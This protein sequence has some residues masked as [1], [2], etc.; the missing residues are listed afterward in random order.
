MQM[1]AFIYIN[2]NILLTYLACKSILPGCG[3]C[4]QTQPNTCLACSNTSYYLSNGN[5]LSCSTKDHCEEC[6]PNSDKC[7]KCKD[8]YYP[9]GNGICVSCENKGCSVCDG[10][11]G[12][13]NECSTGYYPTDEGCKLCS[14][15]NK[16]HCKTCST[17]ENQCEECDDGY[18]PNGDGCHVQTNTV[19]NA[20]QKQEFVLHVVVQIM[21]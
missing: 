1:F 21:Y 3:T 10:I 18:Y 17:K 7:Y 16:P 19:L 8:G 2:D 14:S 9:D 13:C 20:I 4:S 6:N 15:E 12:N 5:C 11:E